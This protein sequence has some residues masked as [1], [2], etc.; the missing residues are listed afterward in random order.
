MLHLGPKMTKF[1]GSRA[2]YL[3]MNEIWVFWQNFWWQHF[4][5]SFCTFQRHCSKRCDETTF[6]W[7]DFVP[8]VSFDVFSASF[9]RNWVPSYFFVSLRL[10]EFEKFNNLRHGKV[11]VL[12]IVIM[13]MPSFN[14]STPI[15]VSFNFEKILCKDTLYSWIL[16]FC[17]IKTLKSRLT[18]WICRS[19]RQTCCQFD[20]S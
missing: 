8:S 4:S 11:L 15:D 19:L 2:K 7:R 14:N 12:L 13:N 5:H 16:Q 10:F 1:C 18:T 9:L 20:Y 6:F 3:K 17:K